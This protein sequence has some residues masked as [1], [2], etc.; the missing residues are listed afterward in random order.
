MD[1][2]IEAGFHF[3]GMS[4]STGILFERGVCCRLNRLKRPQ[5][6]YGM[7]GMMTLTVTAMLAWAEEAKRFEPPA[8]QTRLELT[9]ADAQ[10]FASWTDIANDKSVGA[11]ARGKAESRE[12]KWRA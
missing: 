11:D 5:S 8:Q 6:K 12:H 9:G 4:Q 1:R 3:R 7:I 10:L 2:S